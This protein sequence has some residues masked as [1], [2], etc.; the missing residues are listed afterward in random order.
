MEVAGK[1]VVKR[2]MNLCRI[3]SFSNNNF[4]IRNNQ[5]AVSSNKKHTTDDV[6]S[7]QVSTHEEEV[8]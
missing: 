3:I 5:K 7:D 6:D 2:A 1:F 8:I 4:G